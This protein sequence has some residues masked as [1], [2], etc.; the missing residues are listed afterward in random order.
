MDKLNI[1]A[2]KFL[3]KSHKE[4]SNYR[5]HSG[6]RLIALRQRNNGENSKYIWKIKI[7]GPPYK[8]LHS[9]LRNPKPLYHWPRDELH[10]LQTM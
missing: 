8:T 5:G 3:D 2:E 1:T 7:S 9:Y 10:V 4:R 6:N